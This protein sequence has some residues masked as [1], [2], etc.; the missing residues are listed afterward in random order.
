MVDVVP[1]T[2]AVGPAVAAN[3]LR[4]LAVTAGAGLILSGTVYPHET[5]TILQAWLTDTHTGAIVRGIEHGAP[6]GESPVESVETLRRRITGALATVLDP[7]LREW[8][9]T[10]SQPPSFESYQAFSDGLDLFRRS[11]MPPSPR[12]S[13]IQPARSGCCAKYSPRGS[14]IPTRCTG[15]NASWCCADTRRS[16]RSCVPVD[17]ASARAAC[18]PQ[19]HD[20][21]GAGSA[22]PR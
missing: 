17:T 14:T 8:A 22:G 2:M 20:G 4:A 10:A 1:A 7:R 3:E 21:G 6:P 5:G 13:A 16:T 12:T 11:S 18:P 15:W 9:D 19:V